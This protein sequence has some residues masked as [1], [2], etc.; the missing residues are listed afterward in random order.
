MT[1]TLD[2]TQLIDRDALAS[3]LRTAAACW[4][5]PRRP[6]ELPRDVAEQVISWQVQD[7]PRRGS[8]W[9][10]DGQPGLTVDQVRAAVRAFVVKASVHGHERQAW[11]AVLNALEGRL[12]APGEHE[13]PQDDGIRPRC[14]QCG[15]PIPEARGPLAKFCRNACRTAAWKAKQRET[16]RAA[17]PSPRS[18]QASAGSVRS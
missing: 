16:R 9:L 15:G 4:D 2:E 7:Q 1:D 18:P 12:A 6:G 3:A 10:G 13:L 14:R 17:V 11:Q 8:E 5:G